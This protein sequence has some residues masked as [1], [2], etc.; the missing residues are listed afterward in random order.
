MAKTVVF[1]GKTYQFPDDATDAEILD[2]VERDAAVPPDVRARTREANRTAVL[3]SQKA[4]EPL[5]DNSA[6]QWL[7]SINDALAPYAVAGGVGA[8]AGAP[9]AGVG[10]VPG[11]AAGIG[12]LLLSDIGSAGYN[13]F[14]PLWN[15]Q[16]ITPPSELIRQGTRGVGLSR[17][18]ATPEQRVVH[19]G[20]SGAA[21]GGLGGLAAG[22]GASALTAGNNYMRQMLTTMGQ[23]PAVQAVAGAAAG[24]AP[25][26][27]A[28]AG[29]DN[30]AAL[31]VIS[32]AAGMAT[33]VGADKAVRSAAGGAK[34]PSVEALREAAEQSYADAT[35]AGVE[36]HNPKDPV[37]KPP[38]PMKHRLEPAN[39]DLNR[40]SF[41]QLEKQY[42]YWQQAA[43]EAALAADAAKTPAQRT[44]AGQV[45]KDVEASRDA[46]RDKWLAR[47]EDPQLVKE[48]AALKK[49]REDYEGAQAVVKRRA[50]AYQMDPTE[51]RKAELGMAQLKAGEAGKVEA[52]SERLLELR[53]MELEPAPSMPETPESASIPANAPQFY[54]GMVQ[55]AKTIADSM[56]Y[57][58][59]THP[60]LKE[61]FGR[62][63][64][65]PKPVKMKWTNLQNIVRTI[66]STMFRGS[67]DEQRIG[68]AIV[69]HVED[70]MANPETAGA[71]NNIEAAKAHERATALTRQVKGANDIAKVIQEA[72]DAQ[73][74]Q[75]NTRPLSALL[76]Q[77]FRSM[78]KSPARMRYFN[79]AEKQAII[80]MA[81]GGPALDKAVQAIAQ[82]SPSGS[83]RGIA[84]TS[85]PMLG[86]QAT[87]GA[88]LAVPAAGFLARMGANQMALGRANRVEE[89]M[90]GGHGGRRPSRSNATLIPTILNAMAQGRQ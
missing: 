88:S 6:E 45:Q 33:G 44:K 32:L 63:L 56:G 24:A 72:R 19:S 74:Q 12:S 34:I 69:D 54:K 18:P 9:V 30:P 17:A 66:E 61:I 53:A 27:A 5:P 21:A 25:Q 84:A 82:F 31:G 48:R 77:G 90:R 37:P 42:S 14:A 13:A 57:L 26:A 67:K 85:V 83:M 39:V 10:A 16:P 79:D 80:A 28:E 38:S 8:A 71:G 4:A 70:W 43:D 73:S 87:G 47:N 49:A 22:A 1:N 2:M 23:K 76:Q 58:P 55:E 59:D 51:Q 35:R 40:I 29:V 11:A 86:A 65:G 62:V 89:M 7:G 15:G 36:F 78:S 20:L 50:A 46:V 75:G 41:G 60:M 68:R 81:R 52:I 3:Q 64:G